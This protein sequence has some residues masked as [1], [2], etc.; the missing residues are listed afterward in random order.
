MGDR[1]CRRAERG[2]GRA[3]STAA[4]GRAARTRT[5]PLSAP[6]ERGSRRRAPARRRA[7]RTRCRNG[8]YPSARRRSSSPARKPATSWR[9]ACSTARGS[10]WNVWMRTRPGASRPLRP[11]SWV[12]SWN[13][14]S[15]ARKSGR[16]RPVSASTT[17]ASSTPA[18][19]CPFA[20]ICVPTRTARSARANRSSASRE[21]LGLRD[22]RRRRAGSAPARGRASRARARAAACPRRCARVPA[23]RR[24][25]TSPARARGCRSGGSAASGRRAA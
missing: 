14:R 16:P 17:A 4:Q 24:S 18:K 22:T 21:L 19:W 13:V 7:T 8:G 23:S 1:S 3:A 11:A 2:G 5:A 10:G 15:S 12:R 25:G 20:T 9:A 6:R